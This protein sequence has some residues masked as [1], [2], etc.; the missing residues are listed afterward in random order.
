MLIVICQSSVLPSSISSIRACSKVGRS[1][2]VSDL[3][4]SP[5]LGFVVNNNAAGM[6][7]M[8]FFL[9]LIVLHPRFF[10]RRVCIDFGNPEPIYLI[11]YY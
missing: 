5:H 3:N 7:V 2:D 6:G 1:R 11:V 10:H 9:I 4:L 8:L